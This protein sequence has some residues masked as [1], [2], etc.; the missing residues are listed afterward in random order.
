MSLNGEISEWE[1]VQPHVE[2]DAVMERNDDIL[3]AAH[4]LT[5]SSYSGDLRWRCSVIPKSSGLGKCC[6]TVKTQKL[7]QLWPRKAGLHLKVAKGFSNVSTVHMLLFLSASKMDACGE[8]ALCGRC[9][10]STVSPPKPFCE[11]MMMKLL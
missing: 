11:A 8:N 1:T 7:V 2:E 10:I 9:E 5:A 4:H 3:S 6:L